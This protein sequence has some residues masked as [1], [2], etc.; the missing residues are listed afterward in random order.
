MQFVQSYAPLLGRV[1]LSAIFLLSGVRKIFAW[2]ETA[3]YMASKGMPLVPLFLAGA[4][5]VEIAGGVSI[6]FAWKPKWGAW[7]LFLYLIPVT[8]IFHNFW[9]LAGAERMNQT[10]HL[11]KNITIMGGLAI[12]GSVPERDVRMGEQSAVPNR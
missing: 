3:S 5:V 4:I 2:S 12:L 7:L 1:M 6:L 8:L 10:L 11:M 9:T